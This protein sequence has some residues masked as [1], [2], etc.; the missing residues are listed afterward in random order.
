MMTKSHVGLLDETSVEFTVKLKL[1]G[2]G[3]L[4][5]NLQREGQSVASAMETR[6]LPPP[7]RRATYVLKEKS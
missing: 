1:V 2:D 4:K 3:A 7:R 6:A 5:F